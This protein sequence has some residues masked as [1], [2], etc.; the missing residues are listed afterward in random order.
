[1]HEQR[2]HAAQRHYR[3]CEAPCGQGLLMQPHSVSHKRC[4]VKARRLVAVSYA[5]GTAVAENAMSM[6]P[7]PEQC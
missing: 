3:A 2:C 5:A 1:M 7:M 4:P 6:L